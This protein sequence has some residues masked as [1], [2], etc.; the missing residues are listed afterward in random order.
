MKVFVADKRKKEYINESDYHF[1]DDGDILMFGQFQSDKG[2]PDEISMCGLETRRFTT[3]I[4]V[5]DMKIDRDFYRGLI[6]ESVERS[7]ETKVM[8]DGKY[9]VDVA[10]GF[11][12]DIEEMVDELIKKASQFKRGQKVKCYGRTIT[13]L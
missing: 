6:V 8:E 13:A 9:K 3:N 1:S 12:F 11:V 5:K 2:R 10:W 7:M 4:V